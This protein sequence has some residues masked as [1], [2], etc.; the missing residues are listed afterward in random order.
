ASLDVVHAHQLLQHISDPVA[1]LKEMRRVV[2]PGGIVA[3]RDSDYAT[4]TW[5][6]HDDRL[7]RWVAVSSRKSHAPWAASQTR[8][9]V[10]CHGPWRRDFAKSSPRHPRGA[11]PRE[12]SEP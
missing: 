4:F 9:A 1:A 10:F 12:R 5:H 7:T 2:R 3:A 8:D 11:L 6:P